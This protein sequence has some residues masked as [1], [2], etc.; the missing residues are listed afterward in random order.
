MAIQNDNTLVTKGDLKELYT[1]KIAPY[2]GG[3]INYYHTNRTGQELK[4]GE[5]TVSGTLSNGNTTTQLTIAADRTLYTSPKKR[6]DFVVQNKCVLIPAGTTVKMTATILTG[7][8]STSAASNTDMFYYD[9]THDV[10]IEYCPT[11]FTGEGYGYTGTSSTIF[12]AVED[13]L[14]GIKCEWSNG[15]RKI[16][17]SGSLIVEEI[18]RIVDSVQYVDNNSDLEETPV[19]NIISYMGNSVPKHYLACDGA[20]YSIGSYPELEAFII[21]EFGS[22]NYFGGDGVT[23]WAVPDLRGEFLRGTGTN[24]H[25]NNGNGA[26]VGTHQ[27]GTQHP[28]IGINTTS[29]YTPWTLTDGHTKTQAGIAP[30]QIDKDIAGEGKTGTTALAGANNLMKAGTWSSASTTTNYTS[31][32]TNTSVKYCIKYESTFHAFFNNA[33]YKIE[34]SLSDGGI[35]TWNNYGGDNSGQ[36]CT[37]TLLEGDSSLI[38]TVNKC[39]IVPIDGWYSISAIVPYSQKTPSN[40]SGWIM[41]FDISDNNKKIGLTNTLQSDNTANTVSADGEW[42][43]MYCSGTF[44]LEKGHQIQIGAWRSAND[45]KFTNAKA[46]FCL[47]TSNY[48]PTIVSADSIYSENEQMIGYWKDGKPLYQKT[49]VTTIPTVTTDG[50]YVSNNYDISGWKVDKVISIEGTFKYTDNGKV[51]QIT[52]KPYYQTGLGLSYRNNIYD[53]NLITASNA[54]LF[55]DVSTTITVQYTKTTDTASSLQVENSLLLNRPDLWTAGTEYSF[56][57]GLYGKRIVSSASQTIAA[58]TKLDVPI[59]TGVSQIINSGGSFKEPSQK[60]GVQIPSTYYN[61]GWSTGFWYNSYNSTQDLYYWF[62]NDSSS[63]SRIITYDVW[64]TYKK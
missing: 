4:V 18:G 7:P 17:G 47:L 64:V 40:K 43:H 58:D 31:R 15:A 42:G 44:Y 56:G 27:D 54:M 13:T 37:P 49:V 14:I 10:K 22:I 53:N 1:D 34:T 60:Y 26:A 51:I 2:L 32:P 62:K 36:I 50:T 57:G 8:G 11:V 33:A 23:T 38:D 5:Y 3:G 59:A 16:L 24:S 6:A 29:T 30:Y 52:A 46:S 61:N 35:K 48:N 45:L 63:G 21:D 25:E 39:F 9:Y 28:Y 19:G 41:F 55:N 20:T 12:E